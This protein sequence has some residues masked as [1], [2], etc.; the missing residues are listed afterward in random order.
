MLEKVVEGSPTPAQSVGWEVYYHF[1]VYTSFC[2]TWYEHIETN[3]ITCHF[4]NL[5]K[6]I[7]NSFG[8]HT[9]KEHKVHIKLVAEP[10]STLYPAE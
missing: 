5:V 10:R 2:F 9:T 1:A 7:A 6:N 8:L 3:A 4:E